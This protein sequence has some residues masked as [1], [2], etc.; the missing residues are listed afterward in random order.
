MKKDGYTSNERSGGLLFPSYLFC[1]VVVDDGT[2]LAERYERCCIATSYSSRNAV[3]GLFG[4]F[5]LFFGRELCLGRI[6][7]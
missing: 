5:R 2:S 3:E 6:L 4:Y 1:N 7:V